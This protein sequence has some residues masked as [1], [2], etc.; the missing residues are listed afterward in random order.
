[1]CI[2]YRLRAIERARRK[3]ILARVCRDALSELAIEQEINDLCSD[4]GHWA[5]A[6]LEGT[7]M[8]ELAGTP[9]WWSTTPNPE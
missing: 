1:M 4:R 2:G 5:Q 8:S 3:L 7:D 9:P 6:S